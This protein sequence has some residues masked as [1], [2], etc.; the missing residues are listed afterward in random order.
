MVDQPLPQLQMVTLKKSDNVQPS[1]DFQLD[2]SKKATFL[3]REKMRPS[4]RE[5]NLF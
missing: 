4:P 5:N 2:Q 3:M 1:F